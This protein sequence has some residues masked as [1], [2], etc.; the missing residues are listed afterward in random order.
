MYA[1]LSPTLQID[2]NRYR[3]P[4]DYAARIC[5]SLDFA[6]GAGVQVDALVAPLAVAHGV[7]REIN[8]VSA[9]GALE[10]L[11]CEGFREKLVSEGQ[12]VAQAVMNQRWVDLGQF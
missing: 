8:A 5:R 6:Q 4:R 2:T 3:R 12:R 11:W 10:K 1:D 7:F 9:D